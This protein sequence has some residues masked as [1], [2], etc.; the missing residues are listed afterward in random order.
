LAFGLGC[1]NP[2]ARIGPIHETHSRKSGAQ[3]N[4]FIAAILASEVRSKKGEV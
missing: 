2:C 1:G 4:R 3:A